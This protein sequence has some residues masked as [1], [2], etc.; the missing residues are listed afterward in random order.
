MGLCANNGTAARESKMFVACNCIR[1]NEQHSCATQRT[2]SPI[3]MDSYGDVTDKIRPCPS[4]SRS[5]NNENRTSSYPQA[6]S[7][8]GASSFR[9]L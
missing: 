6:K 7:A 3:M 2:L 1:V 9:K 4:S 8:V 5:P